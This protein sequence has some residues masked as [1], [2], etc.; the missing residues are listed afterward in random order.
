MSYIYEDDY[1]S[2]KS[3]RKI[4]L[5][6]AMGKRQHE[7]VVFC[8]DET[9]GLKAVIAI[10]STALGP[11]LGGARMWNYESEEDAVRDVLRLSRGMTYK[12]AVT[13]LNLGGGKAV[14]IGDPKKDKSEALFRSFGRFVQSLGGRYI[15]AEDVGTNTDDME[16]VR[17]E[18]KHVTGLVRALG[19]SGDPSPVTAY[20]VFHGMRACAEELY[21][22]D[23]L[24]GLRVTIQGLG[25][26]G[27]ALMELLAKEGSEMLITDI[28]MKKTERLADKYNAKAIGINEVFKIEGDIYAPCALGGTVNTESL[29]NFGYKIVAGSANN[30]LEDEHIHGK[31]LKDK[32]ILYAPDYVINA[33]GL[34]NVWNELQGYNKSKAL[35]E[36]KGI[37]GILRKVF[38]IAKKEDMPTN[39]ASNR[40]AEKRI[41]QLSTLKR[42]HL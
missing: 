24:K 29:S 41:E 6:E 28:D 4:S 17:M 32:N 5:F 38:D 39:L 34:I 25:Q 37:Y 1:S 35:N 7:Q 2:E 3:G 16:Y 31:M 36:V 13:G 9:V 27:E 14:I 23:S 30:Q 21:G 19:G 11:S 18:T 12:A 15:T 42:F 40:L 22:T 8:C 10:H 33:G 26:V 20:G